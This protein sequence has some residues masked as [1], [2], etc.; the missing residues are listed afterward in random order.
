M[1]AADGAVDATDSANG[2][3]S[4]ADGSRY[5]AFRGSGGADGHRVSA[6]GG[7]DGAFRAACGAFCAT[8]REVL[9]GNGAFVGLDSA[10]VAPLASRRYSSGVAYAL[11]G[12]IRGAIGSG[13]ATCGAFPSLDAANRAIRDAV[14]NLFGTLG[15]SLVAARRASGAFSR[16]F[17]VEGRTGGG[18]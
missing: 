4:G 11:G 2:C 3:G 16:S 15:A 17:V 6:N 5:G 9:L 18:S 10:F 1:P 7:L 13:R 12:A 14:T 8:R